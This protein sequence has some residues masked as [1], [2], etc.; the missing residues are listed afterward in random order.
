MF[1]IFVNVSLD[2]YAS[3]HCQRNSALPDIRIPR[4]KWFLILFE[5]HEDASVKMFDYLV[6]ENNLE[7]EFKKYN[8]HERD[9][10]FIKE[11]IRGPQSKT[12]RSERT[13]VNILGQPFDS[14]RDVSL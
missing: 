10:I 6:E 12:V 3:L 9:R 8:L 11:Q 2:R 1:T 7:A 5:K 14:P 13:E 4:L